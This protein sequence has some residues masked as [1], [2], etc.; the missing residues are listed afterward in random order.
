MPPRL[1][2][3][4]RVNKQFAFIHD[5]CLT[6]E[7]R[8]VKQRSAVSAQAIYPTHHETISYFE[9]K[10][11]SKSSAGNISIGLAPN[12]M[13][14]NRLPGWDKNSFGYMSNGKKYTSNEEYNYQR[15]ASYSIGDVIGCG[16]NKETQEIFFT[17]NGVYLGTAF[18]NV[19]QTQTYYP[20]IG[21]QSPGD[22]VKANFGQENFVF[23]FMLLKDTEYNIVNYRFETAS[24][25]LSISEDGLTIRYDQQAGPA[26]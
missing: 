21:L 19:P 2:N 9:V 23:D 4:T 10:I 12:T 22:K 17:K 6:F 20:T 18:R 15:N 1:L 24:P 3:S 11:L 7:Y 8:R 25:Q 5:D 13:A 14:S 26:G 16:Y